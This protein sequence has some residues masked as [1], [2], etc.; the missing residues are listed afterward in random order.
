ML[1][2]SA[3]H[4]SRGLGSQRYSLVIPALTLR[5]GE[6]LAIVGPS[7]CGKSTLLDLLALVL[8][9]DQV[10]QFVFNQVD[11]GGLWRGDQHSTLAGL[12]SRHLGYVL[13][14]GGLL[15]FLDVRGNIALSRQLLGLKDDGSVARLAEQLEI[16]D[17]LAK[18]PAALS[19]GQRQRVSCARALAHAPQLVLADEP[20]A[21]LDPLNAE[22]VMQ[23][24]LAQALE[25]RAACVIATH[26]EPLARASGLQVRRITC[27]RDTDGGVTA[28]LG[29]AC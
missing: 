18:K 29:E 5:A 3:V 23:A 1:T 22:R 27:R 15:G 19:V 25:H 9:P 2:V 17:Q 6:Q 26:D 12:R 21:S 8:A 7:G 10:G 28:T 24:L 13:Q 4:K 16:S 14:T 20:T 11:I